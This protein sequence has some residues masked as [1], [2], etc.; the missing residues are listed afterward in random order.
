MAGETQGKMRN[1]LF[2]VVKFFAI[3]LVVVGHVFNKGMRLSRQS[4]M[5]NT[6]L[7]GRV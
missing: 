5:L 4:R 1:P 2:D 3:A 6:V 7:W